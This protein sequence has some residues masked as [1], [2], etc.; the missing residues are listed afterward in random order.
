MGVVLFVDYL[1]F[2]TGCLIP[3]DIGLFVRNFM[4]AYH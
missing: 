3:F 1:L 4:E 2:Y